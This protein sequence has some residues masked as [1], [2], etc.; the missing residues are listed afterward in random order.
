MES[1]EECSFEEPP[2]SILNLITPT[3]S[4]NLVNLIYSGAIKKEKILK[5]I[6]KELW[7]DW[8][9]QLKNRITTLQQLEEVIEVTPKEREGVLASGG[10][11]AMAITPYFASLIDPYN[12]DCPI[13]RQA[14][15]RIEESYKLPHDMVD[16]CGEIITLLFQDLS[17]DT[18]TGHYS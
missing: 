17:T 18:P 1:P 4:E 13:R 3:S 10:R 5:S 14:V 15:P 6:P 9:W 2:S 8:R 12:P 16:P 11:L 7:N